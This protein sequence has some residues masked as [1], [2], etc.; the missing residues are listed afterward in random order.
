MTHTLSTFFIFTE[1]PN[2]L[3]TGVVAVLST[4]SVS[5]VVTYLLTRRK[6]GAEALH[7]T[8]ATLD[9]LANRVKDSTLAAELA[10][11]KLADCKAER[12]ALAAENEAL[13]KRDAH[14]TGLAKVMHHE[15]EH[16]E[17]WPTADSDD[18]RATMK[19]LITIRAAVNEM[20]ELGARTQ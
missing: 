18:D 17:F 19:R 3:L 9:M 16:V 5:A 11:D 6:T 20:V 13:K 8:V 4:S 14:L 12:A 7:T 10:R 15:I 2:E 1:I